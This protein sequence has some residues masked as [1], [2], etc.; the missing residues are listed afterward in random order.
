[1]DLDKD[2]QKA[3]AE[4]RSM[5]RAKAY[6][7]SLHE[8]ITQERQK[9]SSLKRRIEQQQTRISDS[10][11]PSFM[12]AFAHLAGQNTSQGERERQAYYELVMKLQAAESF[13]EEA[14]FEIKVL[15]EKL[16]GYDAA[17]DQLQSLLSQ[18]EDLLSTDYHQQAPAL[19]RIFQQIDQQT[20]LQY[21]IL[22]AVDVGELGMSQIQDALDDLTTIVKKLTSRDWN[23]PDHLLSLGVIDLQKI[24]KL[25]AAIQLTL[26]H[27][28]EEMLDIYRQIKLTEVMKIEKGSLLANPFYQTFLRE[29]ILQVS[30][31]ESIQFLKGI[32]DSLSD[33]VIQLKADEKSHQKN[34]CCTG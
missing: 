23:A 16:G 10:E 13:I 7:S 20:G 33:R 11:K 9:M 1:M 25:T 6:T 12:K 26:N 15:E 29:G 4:Y 3:I 32:W 8:Q 30:G 31:E 24:Q 17:V 2:I 21:E 34:D 19:H 5:V 22:E 28:E 14:T 18:R 27:F